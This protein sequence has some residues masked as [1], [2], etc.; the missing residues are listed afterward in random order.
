M[1][2]IIVAGDLCPK[3][4]IALLFE[5]ECFTEVFE[6]IKPVIERS[7]YAIVN[8]EAPIV[9]GSAHP[10]KKSGPNLKCSNK[11]IEAIKFA[12]FGCVTLANNHLNDYGEEGVLN[13]IKELTFNNIDLTGAGCDLNEAGKILYKNVL[14]EKIAFV[15]CCEH[16]FSIASDSSAGANPI[17]PINQ[18]YVI[19]EAKRNSDKIIVIVHGGVEHFQLPTPRMVKTYRYFIDVGADVVINHH[20]HCYSGYEIYKGRPIFY[21]LGNFCFDWEGK[22]N[23]KWNE[24]YM[25]NLNTKDLSFDLI[26]YY[27]CNAQAKVC[28]MQENMQKTFFEN[29]TMLNGIISNHEELNRQFNEFAV[30]TMSGFNPFHPYTNPYLCALYSHG[31]LPS[32]VSDKKLLIL[33]NKML[34]ES[35]KERLALLF[36][37]INN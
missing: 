21:G 7:D 8:L 17:D 5:K 15:N 29:I 10:I 28:L 16:E 1:A 24:G 34:C 36:K 30:S 32:F 33:Q 31:L 20:Q 35:H 19:Q 22:R 13:T 9:E 26:P 12:G 11:V 6:E 2:K 27:Q 3:D 4:R 37:H 18:Y 25:V 14:G 23:S